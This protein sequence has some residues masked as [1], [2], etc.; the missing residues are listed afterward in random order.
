MDKIKLI[1]EKLLANEREKKQLLESKKNYYKN[2]EK[3]SMMNFGKK[4]RELREKK[5]FTQEELGLIIANDNS[6]ISKLE[7]GSKTP[8]IIILR[9]LMD[10]LEVSA[11]ELMDF[12][13]YT[14]DSDKD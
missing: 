2:Q 10:A 9:R 1:N 7:S 5:G 12:E 11:N 13:L 3:K 8:S 4:L 14:E 6:Y